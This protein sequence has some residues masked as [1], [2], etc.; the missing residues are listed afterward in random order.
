MELRS[1]RPDGQLGTE[2]RNDEKRLSLESERARR[3]PVLRV[4]EQP[5]DHR[6]HEAPSGWRIAAGM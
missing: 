1:S 5:S 6:F 4:T 2:F 3:Y